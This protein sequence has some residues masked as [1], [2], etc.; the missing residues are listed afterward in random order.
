[1][2][3]IIV[4]IAMLALA[5]NVQA[6]FSKANLV[7]G[8]L[9]CS[10]CSKA[11]YKALTKVSFVETVKANIKESSYTIV[12]KKDA[13]VSLDEVRKAV[14]D[15]GFHVAKLQVVADIANVEVKNDSHIKVGS[16]NLHLLD[17]QP[18]ALNGEVVFTLV[19]KGFVSD[20]DYRKY[21]G[22]TTM[23]CYSTGF[24]AS[25]C[26]KDAVTGERIYHVTL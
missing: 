1:M 13:A 9:T 10:M 8:G 2:K 17:I 19:D 18:R 21:S 12:F 25:C 7:A 4:I 23:K 3:K 11:I 26:N 20:K 16:Q 24:M 5:F 15:A 14:V 6:Q 22:Y